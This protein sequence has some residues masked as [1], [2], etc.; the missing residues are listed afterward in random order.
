MEFNLKAG[1]QGHIYLPKRIREV[2][3][4]RMKLLPNATAAVIYPENVA[5][6]DVIKSLQVIISD[7]KLRS[8]KKDAPD[9]YRRLLEK[10][11]AGKSESSTA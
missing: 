8:G 10:S 3:G 7:L 1:S 9:L 2:F 6:E 5:P 4:D 11:P